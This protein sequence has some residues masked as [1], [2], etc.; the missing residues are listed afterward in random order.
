M[1]PTLPGYGYLKKKV[2]FTKGSATRWT[3]EMT[4][5]LVDVIGVGSPALQKDRGDPHVDE[6]AVSSR[7][8][9]RKLYSGYQNWL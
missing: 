5:Y 1:F 9:H 7:G 4:H 6:S 3:W 8:K 2:G